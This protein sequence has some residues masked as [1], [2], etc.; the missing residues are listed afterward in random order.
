MQKEYVPEDDR[1][2]YC[3]VSERHVNVECATHIHIT[4][5]IVLVTDGVLHMTV[6]H[7]EY[8]VPRGC[9]VLVSS[10]EPH[11]FSSPKNNVCH[12]L[13]FS[14]AVVNYFFE[15]LK[16]HVVREHMFAVSEEAL[17]LVERIL[18]A[19][20]NVADDAGAEAVLA[21]LCYDAKERCVFEERRLPFDETAYRVLAY[22][23]E[24]FREDLRLSEVAH[25]V[26]VH[27]V[28]VSR[29]F[30]K[31]TGICFSFYVQYLRC[32]YA[33]RLIRGRQRTFSEIA[34]DAGF[35]SIRSFNRAFVAV[36]RMTPTEYQTRALQSD[37]VGAEDAGER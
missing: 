18:P 37:T 12:V 25:A 29:C 10:L 33:A 24:H 1:G 6:G 5:E 34:Y 26:G 14:E 19:H 30:S 3:L 23:N 36:Y 27:P 15:F 9:G 17:A 35:G 11:A 28:T 21:P 8:D 7:R 20:S 4:M 2:M 32:V 16:G 31:Q 22:A 13:M